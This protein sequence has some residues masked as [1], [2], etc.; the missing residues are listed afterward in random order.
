MKLN[1]DDKRRIFYNKILSYIERESP[2]IYSLLSQGNPI[3]S[4]GATLIVSLPDTIYETIQSDKRIPDL[5]ANAIP[6]FTKNKEVAIQFQKS[7]EGDITDKLKNRLQ[8]TPV[9][10]ENL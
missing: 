7:L 8:A 10:S 1:P 2:S 4:R 3:E 9:D 6:K 5:I